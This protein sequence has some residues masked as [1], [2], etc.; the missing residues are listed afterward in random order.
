MTEEDKAGGQLGSAKPKLVE[1]KQRWATEGR[2][3]VPEDARPA[4]PKL[5]PGQHEVK[6][7]PVLDLGTVPDFTIE[8]WRLRVGGLVEIP[9]TWDWAA[10][11]AQ[12]QVTDLSDMHC[13]TAWSRFDNHWH[14][15]SVQHLLSVVRPKPEARFVML[16]SYDQ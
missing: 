4:K 5:P 1:T 12:P 15:V 10:F 16:H 7:W 8:H 14:G 13:V 11:M 6:D 9:V 2:L 3:L